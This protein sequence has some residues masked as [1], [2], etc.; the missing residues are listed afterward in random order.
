MSIWMVIPCDTRHQYLPAL[1]ANCGLAVENI[2]VVRGPSIPPATI[3]GAHHIPQSSE[4]NIQRW[5][6]IGIDYA[7]EHGATRVLVVNDDVS[8][9]PELIPTM[10]EAM[11]KASA[12]LAFVARQ[13]D[14]R[15][16][17]SCWMLDL[18]SDVRP[19]ERFKWWYGDDDLVQQAKGRVIH[20]PVLGF[21]HHHEA[22]LTRNST[23]L[24]ELTRNDEFMFREKWSNK[25]KN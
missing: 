4:I 17:G 25:W 19:D 16:D 23:E 18:S 5:W 6:N 10:S 24:T 3:P 11:H 7:Q 13:G 15:L 21:M 9:G 8:F 20:V 22:E 14:A 12:A 2:I 1:A